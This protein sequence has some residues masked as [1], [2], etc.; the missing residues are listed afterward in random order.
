[1]DNNPTAE[2]NKDL[3]QAATA[4][5]EAAVEAEAQTEEKPINEETSAAMDALLNEE[6]APKAEP[7]AAPAPAPE[8][9]KEEAPAA[10][11]APVT[12]TPAA[13]TP[14]IEAE[15]PVAPVAP[16]APAPEKKKVS[17]K[18][19][20]IGCAV[21]A[22]VL[23]GGG[24][25]AA[26]AIAHSPEN[27]ALSAISNFLNTKDHAISGTIEYTP[28]EGAKGS[29]LSRIAI[30]IGN[31][32][33][34][35]HQTD[36]SMT[37]SATYKDKDFSITLKSVVIKDYT[38]YVSIEN[39]KETVKQVWNEIKGT[40]Y[41][42][43][44]ELYEDLITTIAGEIDGTWWKISVPDLIDS[45][46]EATASQKQKAKEYYA[47]LT[48]VA[49]K[50][51][52]DTTIGDLYKDNA[53]ITLKKYEGGKNF[54]GKGTAYNVSFSAGKL[55]SF[56]NKSADRA[57]SY[58][59]I[60]CLKNVDPDMTYEKQNVEQEDV[61]KMLKDVPEN[62]YVTIDS[63]FFSSELTGVYVDIAEESYTGKVDINFSRSTKSIAAPSD[64]KPVTEL[65]KNI[66]K[67]YTEW[68]ETYQCRMMKSK[69]PSYYEMYCDPATNKPR[70]EYQYNEF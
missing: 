16:A 25:G 53:F 28:T 22:V 13:A 42:T 68:T 1:M 7:V 69:Y 26:Y 51:A 37:I 32:T 39:L 19:V 18:G 57:E 36:T 56:I 65:Y 34:K 11:A 44:T 17:K 12:A 15:K 30:T 27:V 64:S 10:P 43:V 31:D 23:A 33:D 14:I 66:E 24:L 29:E 55:T 35:D 62:L 50:A 63:G 40:E 52:A 5:N 3:E 48:D 47:C 54:S 59:L 46:E 20:I 8:A 6:E 21:G 2:P 61:E 70:P 60:D 38:I 4:L 58:G 67:A 49:D 9:P 45:V 41:E